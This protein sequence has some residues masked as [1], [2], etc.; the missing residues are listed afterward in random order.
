MALMML[1]G[2]GFA[3]F[4]REALFEGRVSAIL[5]PM[6]RNLLPYFVVVAGFAIAWGQIPWASLFLVSNF[7][8]GDPTQH[9]MLPFDYW[10]VEAYGQLCLLTAL[11]FSFGSVRRA[12][13]RMPFTIAFVA[14]I[15]AFGARYGVPMVYDIGLRKIFL[16]SYVLWLPLLGWCAFFAERN[17]QRLLLLATLGVLAP[18]S[19][20]L[21]G[22]WTAAWVMNLLQLPVMALLLFLPALRIPRIMGPAVM[23]VAAS[24]YHIYLFHRIIPEMLGLDRMG[25]WGIA[26]S[27]TVGVITG[28][29]A[30]ALQRVVLTGLSRRGQLAPREA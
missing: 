8:I 26:A 2:F 12:V 21:G 5:H 16:L 11:A 29:A 19:A 10:F 3:R 7:G 25:P 20:Y 4:H 30:A 9:S 1:V 18:L 6:L 22:N 17:W 14:M 13:V 24:S 15:I 27:V 28:I 23:L